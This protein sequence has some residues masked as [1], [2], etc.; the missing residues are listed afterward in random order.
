MTEQHKEATDAANRRMVE[1]AKVIADLSEDRDRGYRLYETQ[2]DAYLDQGDRLNAAKR[3]L[4]EARDALLIESNKLDA[5]EANATVLRM[6]VDAEQ[7]KVAALVRENTKLGEDNRIA[8]ADIATTL[9]NLDAER[10]EV[11]RLRELLDEM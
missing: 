5:S 2:V 7:A 1:L 3:E 10:A 4:T 9:K 11:A 6:E 8:H